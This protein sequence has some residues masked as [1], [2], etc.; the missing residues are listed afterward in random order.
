[1]HNILYWWQHRVTQRKQRSTRYAEGQALVE[2]ALSVTFLAMLFS[3][4][5]DLGFAYKSYQTLLNATAEASSYLVISPAATCTDPSNPCDQQVL[6][7]AA[8]SIARSRFRNEQGSQIR[9]FGGSTMDLNAD[10]KDDAATV[11]SG[12]GS[13]D[14]FIVAKVQI[15]EADSSQV[16][17]EN[18]DFA[19][20]TSFNPGATDDACKRREKF[21]SNGGQCFIVIRTEIVYKPF[22]IGPA[23]GKQM[24][25]RALSVKPIV[26]SS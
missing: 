18:S 14:Q 23:T 13:F 2:L 26:R 10:G 12:Y 8:D 20:G 1:M 25:I 21:D 22:F 15:D 6:I 11:P 7:N 17:L 19:V 16:T 3:A 4:A 24:I 5:V 9:S